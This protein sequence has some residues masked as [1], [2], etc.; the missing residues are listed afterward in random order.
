M[1]AYWSPSGMVGTHRFDL[2][3]IGSV[4]RPRTNRNHLGKI[5]RLDDTGD[6][7]QGNPFADRVDAEKTIWSYGHRN[8]QGLA[9]D[10]LRKVV[11]ASEH[12]ALGGDELNRIQ[13][14]RQLWMAGGY[15]QPRVRRWFQDLGPRLETW[16][17]GSAGGLDDGYCTLWAKRLPGPTPGLFLQAEDQVVGVLL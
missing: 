15:L 7:P 8:I 9:Y 6:A 17:G 10:S 3:A 16:H 1:K 4:N 2:R 5:L 13:K 14:G 12:G 11:W